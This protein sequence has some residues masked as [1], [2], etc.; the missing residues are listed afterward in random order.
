M[1]YPFGEKNKSKVTI[2]QYLRVISL[3]SELSLEALFS[4]DDV[5]I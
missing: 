5:I 4:N 3:K 2:I 1:V